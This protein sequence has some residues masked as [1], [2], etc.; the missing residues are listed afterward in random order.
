MTRD[1]LVEGSNRRPVL[2]EGQGRLLAKTLMDLVKILLAA[3]LASSFFATFGGYVRTIIVAAMAACFTLALMAQP[4]DTD[5]P[6]E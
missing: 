5:R 4:P 6:K 2:T 3:G 1:T